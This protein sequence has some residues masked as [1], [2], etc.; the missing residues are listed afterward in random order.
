[1]KP[2][3]FSLELKKRLSPETWPWLLTALRQDPWIWAALETTDLGR[4]VIG[5]AWVG[6]GGWTPAALGLLAL[7]D[8][9]Q[10]ADL[11]AQSDGS[12]FR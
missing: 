6:A 9:V 7:G 1:M 8:E 3:P 5:Y 12:N 2:L 11:T 4:Q 10:E